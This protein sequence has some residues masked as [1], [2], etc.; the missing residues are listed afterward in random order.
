VENA[1]VQL[2]VNA[3]VVQRATGGN[4]VPV[5][6]TIYATVRERLAFQGEIRTMTAQVRM[7]AWVITALP[8]GLF[9]MLLLLN[10]TGLSFFWTR[11]PL[12]P[13]MLGGALGLIVVG[14]VVMRRMLVI[15]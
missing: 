12:G 14:N 7:T 8:F 6:E 4:L 15:R 11:W 1:D 9:G 3:L 5:L 13:A 2:L 10:P